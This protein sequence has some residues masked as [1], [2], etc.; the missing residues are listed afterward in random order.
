MIGCLGLL[1]SLCIHL[2]SLMICMRMHIDIVPIQPL[3]KM[4]SPRWV[5]IAS[6]IIW[7]G[8]FF[9]QNVLKWSSGINDIAQIMYFV[10][11]VVL[12]YFGIVYFMSLCIK[13]Q[14]KKWSFL[15]IF[16]AFIPGVNFLWMLMGE[17][18]C[19]L[20]LRNK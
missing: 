10:D 4:E 1:Q 7:I 18:D 20:Q 14:K 8:F 2:V 5:G 9:I 19:L 17:L 6:L 15:S 12:L 13:Y 11:C 16:G 3:S